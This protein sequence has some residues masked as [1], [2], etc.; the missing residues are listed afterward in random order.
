MQFV[1]DRKLLNQEW[2]RLLKQIL[3]MSSCADYSRFERR[4]A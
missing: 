4:E 2:K 3:K 1:R